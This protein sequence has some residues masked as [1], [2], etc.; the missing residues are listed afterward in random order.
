MKKVAVVVLHYK[1]KDF[2][3]QCLESVK[4][5]QTDNFKAETIVINNNPQEDL[6]N[7][8]KKFSEFIFLETGKNLGFTGGN[9]LGIKKA[10]KDGADYV[11]LINNDTTLDPEL[12]VSLV[13]V[14]EKKKKSGLL[15]PMIYFAPGYEY[16]RDRYKKSERGKVIWY[17][18]GEI[19][20]PNVITKHRGADEVD[21]GQFNQVEETVFASGCG[22]LIKKEVFDKIGFLDEKY[23]LYYE[24]SSFSLEAKKAGFQ[25]LFVPQA[26]MWHFNAESSEVGGGLQDYYIARNRLLFGLRYASLRAKFALFRWGLSRL[27]IGRP[28]QKIGFRDFLINR[29]GKG[30]YEA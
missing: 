26:K 5:L 22:M 14:A 9:N 19:D 16:H 29:F 27:I 18:G 7:L 4:K 24:D 23:F 30:S 20:W 17:A 10:L 15:S 28:W 13:K 1:G 25:I 21:K 11:F 2:T 12:L 8:K 3:G 6:K